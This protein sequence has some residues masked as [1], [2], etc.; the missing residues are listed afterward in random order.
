MERNRGERSVRTAKWM[1]VLQ[2]LRDRAR[3][4]PPGDELGTVR[5]WYAEFGVSQPVIDRALAQLRSEGLVETRHGSGI[6]VTERAHTRS[7]GVFVGYDIFDPEQG[8][9]PH[10]LLGALRDEVT[11][12]GG[13]LRYYI[14][15]SAGEAVPDR[16][17]TLRHDVEA[18]QIDGLFTVAIYAEVSAELEV[19]TVGIDH[20]AGRAAVRLDHRGV[21]REG[22]R[23][24]AERGCQRVAALLGGMSGDAGATTA[25][26][27][28]QTRA[29][30]LRTRPEWAQIMCDRPGIS[31]ARRR[32]RE[33]F[34]ALWDAVA[35]KPDGLVCLD[36]YGTAAVIEEL[37]DRGL[38]A[39]RELAIASHANKGLDL[40]HGADVIRI[41]Y[42]PAEIAMALVDALEARISGET[43]ERALVVR[44]RLAR[45][46]KEG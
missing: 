30:G 5:G 26:F 1:A 35:E 25:A 45:K 16:L 37:C 11:R 23:A 18:R 32:V 7:Y 2:A 43:D 42:D 44:P 12:R 33:T 13:V 8:L 31:Y 20:G 34:G 29:A 17:M 38:V 46:H 4:T 10:L 27:L 14:P 9:F 39:G 15:A 24:L 41:E 36:D 28:R 40:F 3:R 6:Y 22:V 21:L 19:P